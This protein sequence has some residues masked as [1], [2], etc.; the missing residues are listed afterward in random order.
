MADDVAVARQGFQSGN[1]EDPKF[2]P[3]Q[4]MPPKTAN[5]SKLMKARGRAQEGQIVNFC[6]FGC[7]NEELSSSGY[8]H[9]LIG[10]TKD[11][12]EFEPLV[13]VGGGEYRIQVK[14]DKIMLQGFEKPDS[15]G[16]RERRWK[17]GPPQVEKCKKGD[18]FERTTNEWRVYRDVPKPEQEIEES[19]DEPMVET[20]EPETSTAQEISDLRRQLAEAQAA[21]A[22]SQELKEENELEAAIRP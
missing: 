15:T 2:N 3:N 20:R 7:E 8:C 18:L 11:K 16:K 21:L 17:W 9:H 5:L 12:K 14:R 13:D 10:F 22:E 1:G 19:L 6:P 4:P